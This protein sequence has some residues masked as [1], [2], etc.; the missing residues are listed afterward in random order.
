METGA[1]CGRFRRAG[2]RVAR[3]SGSGCEPKSACRRHGLV[4]GSPARA[5]AVEVQVGEAGSPARASRQHPLKEPQHPLSEPQHPLEEPQHPL[6]QPPAPTGTPW[7]PRGPG[8]PREHDVCKS[9]WAW[10]D[11][12]SP[13]AGDTSEGCRQR[14]SRRAP[15]GILR[16]PP[17]RCRH[18][19]RPMSAPAP[20]IRP[21]TYG[22]DRGVRS[23]RSVAAP[24][25][26]ARASPR[27]PAG[28]VPAVRAVQTGRLVAVS[29]FTD[30]AILNR[31]ARAVLVTPTAGWRGA[32]LPRLPG[33]VREGEWVRTSRRTSP[34]A[35]PILP[36]PRAAARVS[37][38]AQPPLAQ[39]PLGQPHGLPA[40]AGA[41][42]RLL[43]RIIRATLWRSPVQLEGM[44]ATAPRDGGTRWVVPRP[45]ALPPWEGSAGR[46][47]S[48]RPGP[49]ARGRRRMGS[50]DGWPLAIPTT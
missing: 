40:C 26:V 34:R 19:R 7:H 16:R 10:A 25:R 30:F 31:A 27:E 2:G 49:R 47:P 17:A 29:T 35:V 14:A 23:S 15:R 43:S 36:A 28:H 38:P 32:P 4:A 37:R 18:P 41:S 1:P 42:R 8:R 21:L 5:G 39:V 11:D 33:P 22:R 6:S 13:A 12:P 48:V 44:P 3:A 20:D 9:G 50:V 46:M 45:V 24:S